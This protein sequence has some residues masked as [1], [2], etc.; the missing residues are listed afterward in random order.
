[1]IQ[2][3]TFFFPSDILTNMTLNSS[4]FMYSVTVC[5]FL[6]RNFL[7]NETGRTAPLKAYPLLTLCLLG[8]SAL[9]NW[10]LNY[11]NF[12]TKVVFRSCKL[13]PTMII[14]TF[15]NKR[16][17]T[18]IEY[19][20]AAAISF[21][22]IMFAA[23]DWKLTPSFNP[24]G[25]L[26]VGL[27]VVADSVLPNAQERLFR[28]GASRLEVTLYTNFF[29]LVAMTGITLVS[30]DLKAIIVHAADD[31]TLALYMVVFTAISYAAI[32]TYMQ[33]VKRFGGV[34]AVLL[35]TA[36]KGMTLVLSFMLFPKAFSWYYVFGALM[37]L[38]GLL[39]VSI[40]K[41]KQR[42]ADDAKAAQN[43]EKVPL[44]TPAGVSLDS[45][46]DSDSDSAEDV[47]VGVQSLELE[48]FANKSSAI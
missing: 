18:R 23:A 25:I 46:K 13:I 8:S 2:C 43:E 27:S 39:V 28:F 20:C 29:T 26:L 14:A 34:A 5:S 22:L 21:G 9:S 38:G 17:F 32:S 47:E 36:R 45:D 33:I 1:M 48:Q 31:P 16:S 10:A 44:T 19:I 7:S 35:A 11:I 30:G 42:M 41:Q 15:I 37:V 4:L 24:F 12:P 6:E 3:P 40:S